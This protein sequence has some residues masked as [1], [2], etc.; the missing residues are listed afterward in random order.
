[1]SLGFTNVKAIASV[2]SELGHLGIWSLNRKALDMLT[3]DLK[4][5]FNLMS[6]LQV[7]N[8]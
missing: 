5:T 2:A 3:D 1:M 8:I 4:T 7:R 6:L